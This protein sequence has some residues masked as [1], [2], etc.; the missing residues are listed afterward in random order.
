MEKKRKNKKDDWV[1]D[2]RVIANMNVDGMPHTI[3]S[4][5]ARRG[6]DEFGEKKQK[7]EPL[8]LSKK[9]K[10]AIG[11]GVFIAYAIV[12]LVFVTVFALFLVFCSKVWFR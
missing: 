2:G 8:T 7:A 6:F 1:D 12:A 3:Y 10:R 4:K 5:R 9:E 11:R